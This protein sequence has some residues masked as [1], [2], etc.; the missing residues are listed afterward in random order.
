MLNRSVSRSGI[1]RL[2]RARRRALLAVGGLLALAAVLR[3]RGYDFGLPYIDH[4]D[5]P[6]FALTAL[7][8][9]GKLQVFQN[10][11]YPPGFI[12]L[13]MAIQSFMDILG[14]PAIS[15]YVRVTRL[16]AITASLITTLLVTLNA[17]RLGGWLAGLLAGLT[18]AIA[19]PIVAGGLY[20]TPDPF[21]YALVAA[22]TYLAIEA[23]RR[24]DRSLYALWSVLVGLAA[25]V[26]K[27]PVVPAVIPGGFAA[28]D[29]M[30]RRDRALGLRLLIMQAICVAVVGLWI[31]AGYGIAN[32]NE[33]ATA[34]A[35]GVE[36]VT[37]LRLVQ[38]NLA[39]VF[40]PL[41][42]S[43][44]PLAGWGVLAA[45]AA[46]TL[47]SRRWRGLMQPPPA[48]IAG[49]WA[50][51]LAIPWLATSFRAGSVQ[52]LRD[53]L[54]G[55]T[56]AVTLW[57][58]SLAQ[59]AQA[60][61]LL[62]R[63]RAALSARTARVAAQSLVL[64]GFL[65]GFGIPQLVI[66]W[67]ESTARTYPDTRADLAA[68]AESALEPG[69]VVV[70]AENH[71]TFNRYW[72]GYG[73]TKWFD[74]WVTADVTSY[75]PDGW[76]RR[77]MSYLA[78][79][80][81]QMVALRASPEGR[82]ALDQM[83][84]L[85]VIAPHVRQRGPAMVFFRLWKPDVIRSAAFGGEIRLVGWDQ[86]PPTLQ[87]GDTLTLRFYWQPIAHPRDNY[88]VFLHLTPV[89]DPTQV[90]AQRD[91]SPAGEARLPL[92]WVYPDETLI[93]PPQILELPPSLSPGEYVLRLGLYD[94]V[95]G[96]RLPVAAPDGTQSDHLVILSLEVA[97][98]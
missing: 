36:R 77:G 18:W 23:I 11:Q 2:P 41:A 30:L 91:F 46:L 45:G 98:P 67:Q 13:E 52:A 12:W 40:H 25:T 3:L 48:A 14:A 20:A 1:S 63:R 82:A 26:V 62:L 54:P 79:P 69:T 70:T 24:R 47:A 96:A 39:L 84:P 66:A 55:T 85:R 78:M 71:K 76:R 57:A 35:Q 72:G 19:P 93:G 6:N 73:G 9:R 42:R 74:S 22:S 87:P 86:T 16:V 81:A 80:Y 60:L 28:L 21:A 53:I 34:Q 89:D 8:W 5:E 38:Q 56:A 95:T 37:S 65:A 32:Y 29:V 50:V 4:P 90:L 51:M 92:T 61:A 17:T 27:Y 59:I 15:D 58:V 33:G 83:L 43:T 10:P 94:Y 49:L 31:V 75:S 7:W 64:A 97:A 68:W 88:S 44:W